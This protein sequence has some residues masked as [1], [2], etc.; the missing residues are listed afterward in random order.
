V[1]IDQKDRKALDA[2]EFLHRA[3]LH[4]PDPTEAVIDGYG[5]YANA[6]REEI[7]RIL[8]HLK[9]WPIAFPNLRRLPPGLLRSISTFF[10]N[11]P[12]KKNA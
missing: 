5:H 11:Y 7:I 6:E 1:R 2:V 10:A 9:M 8:R 3:C 4:I 12:I